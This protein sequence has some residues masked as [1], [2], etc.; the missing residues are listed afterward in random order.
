MDNKQIKE[1]CYDLYKIRW[2]DRIPTQVKLDTYKNWYEEEYLP[3]VK[4]V[5]NCYTGE[6]DTIFEGQSFED[7]IEEHGYEGYGI[8]VCYDEFLECEFQD[9]AYI[10]NL[11]DNAKYYLRYLKEVAV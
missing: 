7:W 6:A 8:Y 1:L 2:L 5:F 3:G 4:T 9:E 10:R 11:P